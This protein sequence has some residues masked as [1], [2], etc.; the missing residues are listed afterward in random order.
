MVETKHINNNK[1]ISIKKITVAYGSETVLNDISYQLENGMI[2]GLIGKNGAGKTTLLKTI[3]RLQ[4]NNSGK[5]YVND[6]DVTLKDYLK[7][8]ISYIGDDPVYYYDLTL[9]EHLFFIAK[10]INLSHKDAIEKITYLLDKLKLIKY[11]GYFPAALSKG[12]LQRMNLAIGLLRDESNILLDEPFNALDPVQVSL[13]ENLCME[14]KNKGK[15]MLISSHDI[16]C[17]ENI[18][19]RYLV[20]KDGKIFEF[21]P[22]ELTRAKINEM[23]GESYGE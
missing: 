14:E 7:I 13:V 21:L 22:K 20:L 1:M 10:V 23:I 5:I 17:L 16:E 8:H 12:T 3:V 18:C 4:T 2:Y 9:K 11:A 19:D 6:E 15:C